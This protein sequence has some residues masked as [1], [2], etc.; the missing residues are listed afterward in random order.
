MKFFTAFRAF[1]FVTI[2]LVLIS[3]LL[4]FFIVHGSKSQKMNPEKSD[5]ISLAHDEPRTNFNINNSK[6]F[7]IPVT[8]IKKQDPDFEYKYWVFLENGCGFYT[9]KKMEIGEP[10]AW[11]NPEDSI[12]FFNPYKK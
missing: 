12:I 3:V 7:P 11:I 6:W 1:V 4:S 5:T 10:G 8:E 2:I 9:N